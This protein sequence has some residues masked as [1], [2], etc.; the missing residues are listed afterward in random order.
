[1]T[2]VSVIQGPAP[3]K[4]SAELGTEVVGNLQSQSM[5]S[6]TPFAL[7]PTLPPT[8]SWNLPV[9]YPLSKPGPPPG[10]N[11]S[12]ASGRPGVGWG[13][14]VGVGWGG[15]PAGLLSGTRGSCPLSLSFTRGIIWGTASPKT[16]FIFCVLPS[17][18]RS[19]GIHVCSM[20]FLR[21]PAFKKDTRLVNSPV[22]I[23]R[24]HVGS[25]VEL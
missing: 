22:M 18:W 19:P 14:G 12:S 23:L 15:V 6:R 4:D 2:S 11:N 21:S 3:G 13:V 25:H 1:M 24:C 8:G 10:Q 5:G 20:C 9:P 17:S 7:T 16:T